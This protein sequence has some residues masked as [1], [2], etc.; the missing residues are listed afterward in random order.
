MRAGP[1]VRAS[2]AFRSAFQPAS[3]PHDEDAR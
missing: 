1:P 2:A 3:E